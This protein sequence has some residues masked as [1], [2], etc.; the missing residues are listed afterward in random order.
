MS[1]FYFNLKLSSSAT[2]VKVNGK[3]IGYMW[4]VKV[5]VLR[6]GVNRPR[7]AKQYRRWGSCMLDGPV[8][9][10]N[11]RTP[12][13]AVRTLKSAISRRLR[14]GASRASPRNCIVKPI[15][16]IDRVCN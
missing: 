8:V 5:H 16:R 2:E 10:R 6:V 15:C 1:K 7:G 9:S 3:L 11:S 12:L 13:E 14:V 4:P